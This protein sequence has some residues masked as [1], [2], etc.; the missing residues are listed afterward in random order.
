MGSLLWENQS[1]KFIENLVLNYKFV[2]SRDTYINIIF[3]DFRMEKVLPR[4]IQHQFDQLRNKELETPEMLMSIEK[5]ID[6]LLEK[7]MDDFISKCCLCFRDFECISIEWP[8]KSIF[9][10]FFANY[11]E[12]D[13]VYTIS[14]GIYYHNTR[15]VSY[16]N[17]DKEFIVEFEDIWSADTLATLEPI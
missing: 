2:C 10:L 5:V 1:F 12:I 13:R 16:N 4:E 7:T 6:L 9:C 3:L 8:D 14:K 11:L 17:I 15:E